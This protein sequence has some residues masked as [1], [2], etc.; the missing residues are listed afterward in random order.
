MCSRSYLL[1]DLL[2]EADVLQWLKDEAEDEEDEVPTA[3]EEIVKETPKPKLAKP[4]ATK[5]EQTKQ[6]TSTA[7]K[8]SEAKTKS[9]PAPT[10]TKSESAPEKEVKKEKKTAAP[11]ETVPKKPIKIS[12]GEKVIEA[13]PVPEPKL[14]G[15]QQPPAKN[16]TGNLCYNISI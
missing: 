1:G 16:D 9:K 12:K 5:T 6:S 14:G 11:S 2:E 8:P 15:R 10:K 4:K 13:K 7:D 3:A